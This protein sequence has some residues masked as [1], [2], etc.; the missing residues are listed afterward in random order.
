MGG[1]IEVDGIGRDYRDGQAKLTVLDGVDLE[2]HPNEIVA[3]TGP[4]GSG[5]STLLALLAGLDRPSR[6][7]V[8]IDDVTITELDEDALSR[9]R[10]R[11]IG[12][13]FQSFQLIDTL[14]AVENVQVPA[15]LLGDFERAGEAAALLER[16]GLGHRLTHFPSQLSGGEMQRVAIARASIVQP[17]VLLADEPTGNLDSRA[18]E[19][20][21]EL[22]FER[23]DTAT[24]VVVTHDASIAERA[25]REIRLA[26]GRIADVI[27]RRAS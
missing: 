2:I 19:R 9:F 5:K 11:H 26:D 8:T 21:L 13:I 3:I 17:S 6:G 20:V 14:T 25:D 1:H 7:R 15:E 4:S 12:F 23:R 27:E 24:V 16:V 22:L 18:G 10:G